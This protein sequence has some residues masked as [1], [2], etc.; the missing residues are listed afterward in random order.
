MRSIQGQEE[1]LRAQ[2]KAKT[3]SGLLAYRRDKARARL[4]EGMRGLEKC[5]HV[6][7]SIESDP[8]AV[9]LVEVARA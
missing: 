4:D 9:C 7:A 2:D 3:M 5:G 6:Q 8:I 1:T